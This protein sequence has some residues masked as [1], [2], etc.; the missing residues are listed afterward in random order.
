M[1]KKFKPDHY[2]VVGAK[3]RP[4]GKGI[5]HGEERVWDKADQIIC[6]AVE[7]EKCQLWK[8]TI[9][10]NRVPEIWPQITNLYWGALVELE[11]DG[12]LV[13]DIHILCD[14]LGDF[15]ESAE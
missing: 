9:A 15:I 1:L 6:V 13:N 5:I 12:R 4:A 14:W 8:F 2:I 3:H 7:D 10:P 11:F